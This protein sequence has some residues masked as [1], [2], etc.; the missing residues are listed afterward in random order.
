MLPPIHSFIHSFIR[1]LLILSSFSSTTFLASFFFS[2]RNPQCDRV[3]L[4][5]VNGPQSPLSFPKLQSSDGGR[6]GFELSSVS[7]KVFLRVYSFTAGG[8]RRFP[9]H[10]NSLHHGMSQ[11]K[12]GTFLGATK[13]L[14][15]WLRPLVCWLV[16]HSFDDPHV[17]PY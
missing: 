17:A 8:S 10:T 6:V 9:F 16:T 7:F 15:N 2:L 3:V 11:V 1:L 5:C 14:Y 12:K 13:H 4:S